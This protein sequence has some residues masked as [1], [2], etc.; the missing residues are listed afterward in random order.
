MRGAG[1]QTSEAAPA[2]RPWRRFAFNG[3]ARTLCEARRDQLSLLP[4]ATRRQRTNDADQGTRRRLLR[5]SDT[6]QSVEERGK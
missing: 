5:H 3:W 1:R 6:S 2:F 4:A